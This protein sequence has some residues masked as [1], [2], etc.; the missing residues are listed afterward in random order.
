MIVEKTLPSNSELKDFA[1]EFD[2]LGTCPINEPY[3][4]SED[5]GM[6]NDD[7]DEVCKQCWFYALKEHKLTIVQIKDMLSEMKNN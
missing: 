6:C 2:K 4:T 1:D 7:E 5:H 3:F